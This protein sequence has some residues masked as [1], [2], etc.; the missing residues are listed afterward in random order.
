MRLHLE[1]VLSLFYGIALRASLRAVTNKLLIILL[2]G[3]HVKL[4][5]SS[6][7]RCFCSS[8][9]PPPHRQHEILPLRVSSHETDYFCCNTTGS[10]SFRS[11]RAAP[12]SKPQPT[13]VL[14]LKQKQS[15]TDTSLANR[16][17]S[18]T[19]NMARHSTFRNLP[20]ASEW[21]KRDLQILAPKIRYSGL[22]KKR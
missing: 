18:H 1:P 17:P 20:T 5:Q 13:T 21:Q 16:P 11:T 8:R 22:D 2:P 3:G 4:H 10:F 14:E 12:P 15:K 6:P 7:A 9:G 19:S